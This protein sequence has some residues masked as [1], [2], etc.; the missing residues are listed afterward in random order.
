[1]FRRFDMDI[2][3]FQQV[4]KERKLSMV[5]C[6]DSW[7]AKIINE[8]QIDALLVGDSLG[9]VMHGHDSTVPVTVDMIVQHVQAVSRTSRKKLIVADMPFLSYQQGGADMFKS[10]QLLMQAGAHAIKVEGCDGFLEQI[11]SIVLAGVPV[12]GHLG[13]TPQS[14]HQLGGYRVQGRGEKAAENIIRQAKALQEAGCFSLV[15]EC[16]PSSVAQTITS[17][18]DIPTIGIG[19]GADTSGQILV[20]HDLLGLQENVSFKFLKRYCDGYTMLRDALTE[21]DSEVKS[22]VFPCQHQHV[23]E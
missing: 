8:T 23:Y 12:M 9:M 10:V 6:Y 7:S 4:A 3:K 2:L 11:Q 21:Y 5:T 22:G 16:V 17:E 13:L 14:V 18:L 15:L 1:M 20:F 19:A